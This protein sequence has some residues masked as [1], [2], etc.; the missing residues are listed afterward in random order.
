[1]RPTRAP[2][3][4]QKENVPRWLYETLRRIENQSISSTNQLSAIS[5][6]ENPISG[7]QPLTVVLEHG[8]LL[9]LSPYDDHPHYALLRGRTGGQILNGTPL[10][11]A[12]GVWSS[13]GDFTTENLK[14]SVSTWSPITIDTTASVNDVIF[15]NLS[16][17]PFANSLNQ[18]TAYHTSIT[19]TKGNTWTKLKEF[20]YSDGF[21][22]GATCSVWVCIVSSGLTAGVDTLSVAYTTA[23]GKHAIS[24]RRFTSSGTVSTV[25]VEAVVT[26][27]E[28]NFSGNGPSSETLSGLDSSINY[29]WLRTATIGNA[30]SAIVTGFNVTSNYTAFNTSGASTAGG[31]DNVSSFTEFRTF[32]AATQVTDPSS[33]GG[34]G[35]YYVSI[36]LAVTN[37]PGSIG[38]L[39]LRA[40]SSE[41]AAQIY[42]QNTNIQVKAVRTNFYN[43]GGDTVL[44]YI[45]GSDGAF[46][47]PI[48]ATGTDTH[49]D[50]IFQILGSTTPTKIAMFEVDG[51]AAPVTRTFTLL[52]ANVIL[53]GSA[54]ALT[55]N[56]V[57]CTTTG[58]LLIDYSTLTFDG[59]TLTANSIAFS[60]LTAGRI[61]F[62]AGSPAVLSDSGLLN[63]D[64]TNGRIGIGTASPQGR[65]HVG[66]QTHTGGSTNY[67]GIIEGRLLLG[68]TLSGINFTT[69]RALHIVHSIG[70][71]TSVTFAL[72]QPSFSAVNSVSGTFTGFSIQPTGTMVASSGSYT[73]VGG[74]LTSTGTIVSSGVT[75]ADAVAFRFQA[76]PSEGNNGKISNYTGIDCQLLGTSSPLMISDAATSTNGTTTLTVASTASLTAGMWI[77]PGLFTTIPVQTTIVSIDSGTTLTMSNSA[78]G[79][80]G[81]QSCRFQSFATDVR[82]FRIRLSNRSAATTNIVGLKF[83]TGGNTVAMASHVAYIWSNELIGNHAQ[84]TNWSFI[85]HDISP[86]LPTNVWGLNFTSTSNNRIAGKLSLGK[87]TAPTSWLELGAG[88]T[89]VAPLILTSGT[90]LTTAVAGAIE[91][92]TD[93]FFATITTGTARK[94]LI[95]DDGTRLISGRVPF[96]TTNGRLIDDADLT[97]ATDT[98]TAT[99]IIGSTSI[100]VGSAAG[101]LSSDG[102]AGATGTFTTVDLKTVTV[103]DGIIT[104]IV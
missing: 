34:S 43:A 54:S 15:L 72:I 23:I 97:F 87:T 90:S 55:T 48:V 12:T 22:N 7:G 46:V 50:N 101:Y 63:W 94:A 30:G 75:C 10:S 1:M 100:K 27:G 42:L 13:A 2:S 83:E 91:F 18:I 53:A 26:L 102:S 80:E 78:T 5:R 51:F 68:D 99:K 6:G 74:Q 73:F 8:K 79:S 17:G 93:D 36:F 39:K 56:R 89:T 14:S 98:L 103:K 66:A 67:D 57:A 61:P 31:T 20:S 96:A 60:A 3:V 40:Y 58:G 33:G 104:A 44:S 70:T 84:V 38:D 76:S 77:E 19:D 71:S 35:G 4:I 88:T 49:P 16:T 21:A 81:P 41:S 24:S 86:T 62:S 29:L 65:F 37:V 95:L 82:G 64:Q 9:K 47:G 92:T 28:A 69:G 25:S 52:D 32:N 11:T 59:T 85:K 45:R